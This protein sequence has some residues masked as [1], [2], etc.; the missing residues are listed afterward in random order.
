MSS[1]FL[2]LTK[3]SIMKKTTAIIAGLLLSVASFAQISG[4]VVDQNTKE[5]LTGATVTAG[6][7]SVTS[8][9]DG[10]FV[11]KTAKA[12]DKLKVSFVGYKDVDVVAKD[13]GT[14]ELASTSIG[15]DAVKVVASI[16]I[17]RKTPV[18]ISTVSARYAA[19]NLG[20]QI[21]RAHV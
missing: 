17:D 7:G 8:G 16:G 10:T 12:G 13:G 19:E 9:L 20:S 6:K 14:I 4:K 21:G 5:V 11:L 2:C 18:A 3:N 15:L 1:L